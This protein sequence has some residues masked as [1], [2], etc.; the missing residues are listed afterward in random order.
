MLDRVNE[1]TFSLSHRVQTGSGHTQWIS[2]ALFPEVKRQGR[3]ADHC[4][5]LTPR[6]KMCGASYTP[7]PPNVFRARYL[8]KHSDKFT[9]TFRITED[10]GRFWCPQTKRWFA[11]IRTPGSSPHTAQL[12]LADF[13]TVMHCAVLCRR[14]RD[15]LGDSSALSNVMEVDVTTLFILSRRLEPKD[16]K[17]QQTRRQKF[18]ENYR[19]DM[20]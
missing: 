19:I 10:L 7:P 3:E 11:D 9:F 20:H 16:H 18:R 6:L 8:V 14:L 5:H 15:I 4:L 13:S 2:R 12:A 17:S 1:W